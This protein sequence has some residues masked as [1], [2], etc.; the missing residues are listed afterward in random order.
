MNNTKSVED[1]KETYKINNNR[2]YSCYDSHK[3]GYLGCSYDGYKF[4]N[5]LNSKTGYGYNGN[6]KKFKK[7]FKELDEKQNKILDEWM[8]LNE[9]GSI[10]TPE[11]EKLVKN[12]IK[13]EKKRKEWNME[14]EILDTIMMIQILKN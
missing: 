8:L 9:K 12:Y 5:D 1:F 11:S 2:K 6:S 4:K 7:E 10:D 3:F 14:L 13:L